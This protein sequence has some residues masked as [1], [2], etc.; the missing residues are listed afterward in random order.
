MLSRNLDLCDDASI[1][2]V[3]NGVGMKHSDYPALFLSSDET[4][5]RKQRLHLNLIRSEY[6]LLLLA[7]VFSMNYF[8]GTAFYVIYACVF[9][10]LLGVL[11]ARA[12]LRPV[13]CWYKSRALAESVKTLTWRYMMKAPPFHG[14]ANQKSP[15]V[16][17]S[18]HL[19]QIL[20]ANESVAEQGIPDWSDS[21]QIT[22]EMDRVRVLNWEERREIYR[23]LRVR[24]QRSWYTRKA[25]ENRGGARIWITAGILAYVFA[26]VM[27][28]C[29]I[30]LSEWSFWP[31]EP[32]IVFASSIVGWMQVKK[33]GELAA[34]YHV[35]A[36]EIGFLEP[37][38]DDRNSDSGVASF[39]NDAEFA[40]SREHTMWVARQTV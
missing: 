31:I 17:F 35:T 15:R 39:V 25:R 9:L 38:L 36:Q 28:L 33:F 1:L 2:N 26:G 6:T 18:E 8:H 32:V 40:F 34:A 7:A 24:E 29:R 5:N 12:Y 27:T 30:W 14:G 10:A 37:V 19:A 11:I 21:S 16:E 13:Q 3:K 4:S 20:R 22:P 23:N